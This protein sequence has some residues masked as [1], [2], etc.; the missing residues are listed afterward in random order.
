MDER[1]LSLVDIAPDGD[2]LYNAVA[3]QLSRVKGYEQVNGVFSFP[4][5]WHITI[6]MQ[7]KKHWILRIFVILHLDLFKFRLS[8]ITLKVHV[9]YAVILRVVD[10]SCEI[11]RDEVVCIQHMQQDAGLAARLGGLLNAAGK[12]GASPPAR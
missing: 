5:L 2:C 6:F 10:H 3:N 12:L 9:F 4:V 7:K 1:G 8:C 11:P